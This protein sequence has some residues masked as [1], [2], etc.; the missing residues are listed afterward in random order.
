MKVEI[1]NS[2][3]YQQENTGKACHTFCLSV[4]FSCLRSCPTKMLDY[5]DLVFE[6]S[7]F[8]KLK[9]FLFMC[10][11]N[12]CGCCGSQRMVMESPGVTGGSEPPS[13]SAGSRAWVL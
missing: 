6:S 3:K 13:V 1:G 4:I 10:M 11:C 5:V 7:Q 2:N 8:L 12:A 9:K